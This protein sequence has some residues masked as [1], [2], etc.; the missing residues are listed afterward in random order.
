MKIAIVHDYLKEFGGAERVVLALHK[1]FPEAPLYTAY[2]NLDSLGEQ[3][4]EFTGWEIKTSW[5]QNLPLAGKLISPLRILAASAFQG[6]NLSSYDVVISSCAI[7]FAKA[8][9]VKPGSL[10]ISYIHTPPRYLYGYTTSYNYQKHW[11][12]KVG[13]EIA[14]HFLRLIDFETSQKPDILVANSENVAGRIAK[15]YR[16][17]AV[18]IYP[19]VD[20]ERFKVTD[21][22]NKNRK[23]YYLS[24]GRLVRGKGIDVIVT[25]CTKLKLPLKVVGDGPELE[26]L[27]KLTG[28][29]IEF[30]GQVKDE[31]LPAL[32]AGAK[33][34]IVAS[35]DEDFG[36]VPVESMASGTPVIAPQAGGFKETVV[37]GKTGLFFNP[38][39][40]QALIQVLEKFD[41]KKFMA[42]DCHRQAENFSESRF[43]KAILE[44]IKKTVNRMPLSK[45]II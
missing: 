45:T 37:E 8:V 9:K 18:V 27:K 24:V 16:R 5:L 22:R 36:I 44:L 7:Y 19:P 6:F 29:T 30:L 3:K 28:P 43:E 32:Y 40:V 23:S 15:F 33:A 13:G 20:T 35:E 38:V 31:E 34:T 10:H 39:T 11:L 26:N 17:K 12:T 25:A 21:L 2:A 4:K 42:K 14:N 1:I 41:D